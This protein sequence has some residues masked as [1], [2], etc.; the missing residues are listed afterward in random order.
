MQHPKPLYGNKLGNT[1]IYALYGNKLETHLYMS[2]DVDMPTIQI[3][4]IGKWYA[5]RG[6]DFQKMLWSFRSIRLVIY[7]YSAFSQWIKA[8]A[9]VPRIFSAD[10]PISV[11]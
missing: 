9:R 5:E 7:Q 6:M 3:Y 8:D 4:K 10:A 2:L 1:S 11:H